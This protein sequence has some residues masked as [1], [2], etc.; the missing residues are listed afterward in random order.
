MIAAAI[1][2]KDCGIEPSI[3]WSE[4]NHGTVKFD[5]YGVRKKPKLNIGHVELV[6]PRGVDN[7]DI[8]GLGFGLDVRGGK[9]FLKEDGAGE[10]INYNY[11]GLDPSDVDLSHRDPSVEPRLWTDDDGEVLV[12][13]FG[14]AKGLTALDWQ[15]GAE[16]YLA[17]IDKPPFDFDELQEKVACYVSCVAKDKSN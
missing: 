11:D 13:E 7:Y 15:F 4:R 16:A 14:R 10:I 17:A 9:V 3:T 12:T 5:P 1:I 8:L 6:V 2:V